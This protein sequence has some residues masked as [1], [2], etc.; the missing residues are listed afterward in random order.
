MAPNIKHVVVL[1]LENRSFDCML[2]QL[3]PSSKDFDGLQCHSLA[4]YRGTRRSRPGD[5]ESRY[6]RPATRFNMSDLPD[7]ASG[8]AESSPPPSG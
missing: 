1:M 4:G 7:G 6:L 5:A 2:G 8:Q 3:R